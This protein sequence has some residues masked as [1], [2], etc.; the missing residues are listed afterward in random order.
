MCRLKPVEKSTE[1]LSI[2]DILHLNF[3]IQNLSATLKSL[4]LLNHINRRKLSD[5]AASSAGSG[6]SVN[7]LRHPNP[8]ACDAPENNLFKS[9]NHFFK[10]SYDQ[11]TDF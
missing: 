10:L 8:D 5:F 6:P 4:K 7:H 3:A 2:N 9:N 1:E 11:L